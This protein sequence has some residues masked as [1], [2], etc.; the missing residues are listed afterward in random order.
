[1]RHRSITLI[2][3][4]LLAAAAWSVAVVEMVHGAKRQAQVAPIPPGFIPWPNHI[5]WSE[6]TVPG[7]GWMLCRPSVAADSVG[8]PI[9]CLFLP[10]GTE[11]YVPRV[12]PGLGPD[13]RQQRTWRSAGQP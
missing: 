12:V 6:F 5:E 13:V 2:V 3:L 9:T 8:T 10:P 4:A 11:V 1:M 7:Q